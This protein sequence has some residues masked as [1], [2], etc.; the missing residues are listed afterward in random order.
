MKDDDPDFRHAASMDGFDMHLVQQPPN[1]PDTNVL[2]LGFFNIIQTLQYE[3]ACSTLDELVDAVKQAF[4][5]PSTL[6]KVFLS[7]QGCLIEILKFKGHNNFKLPHMGKDAL[8]RVGQLP[9]HLEVEIEVVK[10]AIHFMIEA[11]QINGIFE[12]GYSLGVHDSLGILQLF[13]SLHL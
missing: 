9:T 7:L 5:S 10:E 13:G 12:L 8:I 2:D 6:N 4:V 1:S 11:G 3:S